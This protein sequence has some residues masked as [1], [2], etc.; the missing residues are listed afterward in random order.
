MTTVGIWKCRDPGFADQDVVGYSVEARDGSFGRIEEASYETCGGLGYVVI[1]T[2]S[3]RYY[4]LGARALLPAAA[5]KRADHATQTV[6]LTLTREQLKNAPEYERFD[7][8]YREEIA[9]Y[10]G[11]LLT[12]ADVVA[13]SCR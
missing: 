4:G 9:A 8:A 1:D 2:S 13:P 11:P 3:L 10:Y 5:I 12:A 6:L 7:D